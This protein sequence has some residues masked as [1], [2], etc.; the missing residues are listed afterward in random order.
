MSQDPRNI[1]QINISSGEPIYRQIIEQTSRQIMSGSLKPGEE[2]PSVRNVALSL[3]V[4]PMTVSKAYAILEATGLLERQRGK[5]MIVSREKGKEDLE[6]RM[7]KIKPILKEAAA[8]VNQL[9]LPVE[10]ILVLFRE[11][12]EENDG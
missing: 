9:D 12:L 11:I 8:Q 3:T 7:E 1:Y 6:Q 4:N 2:L 5:G 10:K